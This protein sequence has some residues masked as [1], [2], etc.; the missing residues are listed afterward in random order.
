M[1][2]QSSGQIS[3]SDI[4][5]EKGLSGQVDLADLSTSS[6][7]T[8]STSRPNATTPH[9]I[10]EFYSYQHIATMT[11]YTDFSGQYGNQS[12]GD[13]YFT[14]TAGLGT[15][16]QLQYN[17]GTNWVNTGSA[18]SISTSSGMIMISSTGYTNRMQFTV[19]D[20]GTRTLYSVTWA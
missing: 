12:L 17:D 3:F 1:A 4:R 2:L 16:Y 20:S 14:I 15:S 10:N 11:S 18:V 13:L 6:I 8:Y 19:S 9:A 7:N 5:T